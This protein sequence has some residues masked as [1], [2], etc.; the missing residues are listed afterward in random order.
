[1]S[2][3]QAQHKRRRTAA[4]AAAAL[5]RRT[6]CT[7]CVRRTVAVLRRVPSGP[8]P[9]GLDSACLAANAA[10]RCRPGCQM[11]RCETW[12][13]QRPLSRSSRLPAL[14]AHRS[15]PAIPLARRRS[16]VQPFMYAFNQVALRI[17]KLLS[18]LPLSSSGDFFHHPRPEAKF[19]LFF[20][21]GNTHRERCMVHT[22]K[23]SDLREVLAEGPARRSRGQ[24]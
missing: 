17:A 9:S 20:A 11:G 19:S 22:G 7:E 8:S 14:L 4:Q 3:L 2:Y 16:G 18:S 12:R 1:M 23:S 10:G 5:A 21:G 13:R 6:E 24:S 15:K